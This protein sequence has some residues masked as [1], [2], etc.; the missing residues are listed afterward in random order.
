[1]GKNK[2]KNRKSGKQAASASKPTTATHTFQWPDSTAKEVYVTGTFDDWKKT[3]K[4]DKTEDGYRKDVTLPTA[5]PKILY[6]FV[7]DD[8]WKADTTAPQEDDGQNNTNNVLLR[9]NF[10]QLPPAKESSSAPE[11]EEET[12]ASAAAMSGVTP[13]SATATLTGDV[14]KESA[15]VESGDSAAPATA[16]ISSAAPD[17]TTAG[18]AKDAPLEAKAESTP[19][20]FPETPAKEP[21]Q[22]S[23]KPI[24]ASEGVGNPVVLKPGEPVPDSSTVTANTVNSTVR[25]DK[26]GYEQDASAP[27]FAPPAEQDSVTTLPTE[28]KTTNGPVEPFVQSAAPTSTTAALAGEVPLE[29]EKAKTSEPEAPAK[30]VPDVVKDSME[31]AHKEPEAAG[32]PASVEEK[33]EVEQQILKDVEPAEAKGEAAESAAVPAVVQE[34]LDKAHQEPEAAAVPEAV[35]EKKEVEQE[36]LKDVKPVDTAGEP[37]PVV[38]AETSETAPVATTAATLSPE[39]TKND[40]ERSVSPKSSEPAP[41]AG[42]EARPATEQAAPTVTTGPE[43]T[44]TSAVSQPP[45]KEEA[46][47]PAKKEEAAEPAKPA[48]NGGAAGAEDAAA[49]EKTKKKKNRA[50][51]LFSKLKEKFR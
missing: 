3:V 47:E 36:L 1:M 43:T 29:S 7:V 19:G 23:V 16:T 41:T 14:P 25:T 15:P 38:T 5:G 50:S 21:E 12:A 8:I 18:L 45:K 44:E 42:S 28:K 22:F 6:K 11:S 39:D 20:T 17:S 27:G 34:S 40:Q 46:T 48:T 51:A 26:E 37:A 49:Q 9:Q 35:G 30:D 33:K 4:L 13:E 10:K 24:P 2:N 31:K 32:V